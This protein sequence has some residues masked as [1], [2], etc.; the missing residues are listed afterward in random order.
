[1]K[2]IIGSIDEKTL[3]SN[4]QRPRPFGVTIEDDEKI[5]GVETITD[6]FGYATYRVW[7]AKEVPEIEND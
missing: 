5:I 4:L 3:A 6:A 7:I 1:M 2:F